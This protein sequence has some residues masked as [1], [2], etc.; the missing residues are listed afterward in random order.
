MPF[1]SF[2][3]SSAALAD[4]HT[5]EEPK[6]SF[7]ASSALSASTDNLSSDPATKKED[8]EKRKSIFSFMSK[9]GGKKKHKRSMENLLAPDGPAATR[10]PSPSRSD[11]HD[12]DEDLVPFDAKYDTELRHS[13]SQPIKDADTPGL[14]EGTVNSYLSVNLG[15]LGS[16]HSYSHK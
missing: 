8:K 16:N 6:S 14:S 4:H 9:L 3:S 1:D 11:R 13:P 10:D 7:Q 12:N 2:Q 5:P 15:V